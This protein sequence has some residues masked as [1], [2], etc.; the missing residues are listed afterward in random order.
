VTCEH[1][2]W[3]RVEQAASVPEVVPAFA[4]FDP[5]D[6]NALESIDLEY[7]FWIKPVKS[8]SSQLGFMIEN[9]E[10]FHEAI[11]DIREK[12]HDRCR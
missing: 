8:H 12:I 1:K 10:Q 6:D 5:F 4:G 9:A 3:S 7:P 2:Y 11:P